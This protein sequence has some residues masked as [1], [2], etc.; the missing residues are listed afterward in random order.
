MDLIWDHSCINFYSNLIFV[1]LE[2]NDLLYTWKKVDF[3]KY[4]Q[5]FF[6][7]KCSRWYFWMRACFWSLTNDFFIT[8]SPFINFNSFYGLFCPILKWTFLPIFIYIYVGFLFY[9]FQINQLI[10]ILLISIYFYSILLVS[11]TFHT[12]VKTHFYFIGLYSSRFAE[13]NVKKE[14]WQLVQLGIIH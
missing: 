11:I 1:F 10:Y 4:W 9:W 5:F 7:Q 13:R 12:F 14:N 6:T 2:S 3:L 8:H